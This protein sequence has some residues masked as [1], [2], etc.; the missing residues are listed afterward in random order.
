M[1]ITQVLEKAAASSDPA[2]RAQAIRYQKL[3]AEGEALDAFFA[4][5]GQALTE[6]P[7]TAAAP[8]TPARL[9]MPAR[10]AAKPVVGIAVDDF[11]ERVKAA[12]LAHGEPVKVGKLFNLFSVANP[13]VTQFNADTFRQ[14]LFKLRDRI[15][16]IEGRGYWPAGHVVPPQAA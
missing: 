13:D 2:V 15:Q 14:K 5:Y 9:P 1:D 7:P 16:L 8:K 6:A 4:F 11:V 12:L 10:P 3:K